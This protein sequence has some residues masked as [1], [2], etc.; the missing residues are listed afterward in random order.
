MERFRSLCPKVFHFETLLPKFLHQIPIAPAI[1][2]KHCRRLRVATHTGPQTPYS[3]THSLYWCAISSHSSEEL[4]ISW[5]KMRKIQPFFSL[6]RRNITTP[7]STTST[8][9]YQQLCVLFKTKNQ[10]AEENTR[11]RSCFYSLLP[12][13]RELYSLYNLPNTI[14]RTPWSAFLPLLESESAMRHLP[15]KWKPELNSDFHFF[16]SSRSFVYL[17]TPLNQARKVF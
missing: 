16:Y 3:S 10:V 13:R 7:R 15:A 12:S 4:I 5:T 11:W 1:S 14:A 17:Q 8:F 2:S 6:L 9:D